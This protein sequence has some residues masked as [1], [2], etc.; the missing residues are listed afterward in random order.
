MEKKSKN[1]KPILSILIDEDKR[2]RF[3]EL[4]RQNNLSMG[5]LVNQAIDKMLESGSINIYKSSTTLIEDLSDLPAAHIDNLAKQAVDKYLA[6]SPNVVMFTKSTSN[7]STRIEALDKLAANQAKELKQIKKAIRD[8]VSEISSDSI[9]TPNDELLPID[10]NNAN[11]NTLEPLAIEGNLI[12]VSR[13]QGTPKL[14]WSAFFLAI[15]MEIEIIWA[16]RLFRLD[17]QESRSAKQNS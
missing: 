16:E 3:S 6:N 13:F 12:N 14:T 8:R 5:W 10:I 17:W 15:G 9:S 7:I 4:A 2:S 11:E 1:N